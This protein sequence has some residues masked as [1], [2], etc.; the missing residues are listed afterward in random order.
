MLPRGARRGGRCLTRPATRSTMHDPM[1]ARKKLAY[2][3]AHSAAPAPQARAGRP[4]LRK[5]GLILLCVVPL[6]L[7]FAPFGQFYL[8]WVGM[9]PWPLA[10]RST[11]A[12]AAA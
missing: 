6:S 7:A 5:V 12:E 2:R 3:R 11:K 10:V 4:W 8:A 9:V 1:S